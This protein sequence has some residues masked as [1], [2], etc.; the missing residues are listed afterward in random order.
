MN[1]PPSP[2]DRE[3]LDRMARARPVVETAIAILRENENNLTEGQI[4][5]IKRI[6]YHAPEAEAN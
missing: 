3:A 2:D 6:I 4:K 1:Q 5:D